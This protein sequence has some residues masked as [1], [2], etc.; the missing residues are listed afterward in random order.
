[1]L[2][3]K[4]KV[5]QIYK[6]TT[7]RINDSKWYSHLSISNRGFRYIQLEQSRFYNGGGLLQQILEDRKIVRHKINNNSQEDEENVFKTWNT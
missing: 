7:E 1:M 3:K 5:C 6:A 4:C 2:L